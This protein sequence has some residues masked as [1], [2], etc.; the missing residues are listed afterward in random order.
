MNTSA[1]KRI[2]WATLLSLTCAAVCGLLG[3]FVMRGTLGGEAGRT[4]AAAMVY[5]LPL[6]ALQ[7]S[8]E[9]ALRRWSDAS[10]S[11]S[12][13]SSME[14]RTWCSAWPQ[15]RSAARWLCFS[16]L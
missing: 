10:H 14:G 1:G 4:L 6:L 3:L 16:G 11:R 2:V 5:A 15:P 7:A 9:K 13:G 8:T 12:T